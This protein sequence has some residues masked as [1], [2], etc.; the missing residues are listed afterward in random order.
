ME[1]K[2]PV[3]RPKQKVVAVKRDG[4]ASV[5]FDSML[6]A[7]Q[8]LNISVGNI[9]KVCKGLRKYAGEYVFYTI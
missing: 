6:E 1:Q 4:S 7:S 3:G 8:A 5:M 2:R 9:S